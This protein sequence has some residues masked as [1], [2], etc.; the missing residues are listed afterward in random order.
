M[1]D[2]RVRIACGNLKLDFKRVT[3][4]KVSEELDSDIKKTFDESVAVPSGDGGYTIDIDALEARRAGEF[5]DLKR[6][7][8]RMKNQH[9]SISVY[10]TVRHKSGDFEVAQ[11]FTGVT[12]SSNE[13]SY[14]A[15]DL[16]ARSLSFNAESMIEKVDGHEVK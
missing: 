11:Y 8:K 16:T 1:A 3:S 9:G 2:K 6:I 4:V 10:E 15:E 12:L 13:G 5:F 14:D 7:L